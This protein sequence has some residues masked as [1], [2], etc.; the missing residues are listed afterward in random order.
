VCVYI[1]IYIHTYYG[2]SS[3][4][5]GG[6]FRGAGPWLLGAQVLGIVVHT[7]S[8]LYLYEYIIFLWVCV[9]IVHVYM[10]TYYGYSSAVCWGLFRGSGPWLFGAQVY[11]C[12][13][14]CMSVA[15]RCSSVSTYVCM[16]VRGFW[17][18]KC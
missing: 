10:Y 14:V 18:P 5:G 6:L 11:V 9:Y 4:V 2:S 12:M 3:L 7:V 15:F 8:D 17:V 13:H 1:Y 16:Y